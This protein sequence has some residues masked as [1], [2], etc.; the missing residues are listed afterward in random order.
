[1]YI[2][3]DSEYDEQDYFNFYDFTATLEGNDTPNEN[4]EEINDDSSEELI[5]DLPRS[6]YCDLGSILQ[7]N[8]SYLFCS[9]NPT[10]PS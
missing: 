6:I 7:L 8:M 9:S 5:E 4:A 10:L 3:A 2:I 1:M